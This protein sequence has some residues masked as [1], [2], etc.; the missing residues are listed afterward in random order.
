MNKWIRLGVQGSVYI[1]LLTAAACSSNDTANSEG[2]SNTSEQAPPETRAMDGSRV[3]SQLSVDQQV[4]AAIDDLSSRVGLPRD[5]IS[6]H[7][8]RSV[9][10][11]SGAI[12]CPK[13]GMNYT[14][15]V[16]PGVLVLLQAGDSIYRYHGRAGG[17]L[18]L[19]P[20]ER[21]EAP[22]YGPGQD[23]M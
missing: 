17:A 23:V 18:F 4:Y 15:A 7:Q 6:I 20:G 21:A 8:A 2:K 13:E 12:G 22:A 19:C 16:V 14:Q 3:E 10:W 9:V 11:G 1:S 5:A